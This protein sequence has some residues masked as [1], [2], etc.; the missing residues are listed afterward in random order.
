[1]SIL[2]IEDEPLVLR[3]ECLALERAG[4]KVHAAANRNHAMRLFESHAHEIELLI[5]DVSISGDSGFEIA[6][7]LRRMQPGL[8]MLF[9]SGYSGANLALQYGFAEEPRNLLVKPFFPARLVVAVKEA[10]Q[11]VTPVDLCSR[12]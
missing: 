6:S 8:R 12:R 9:V 10:M 7:Q 2:L 1:M 3:V 11:S 5:T 4:F